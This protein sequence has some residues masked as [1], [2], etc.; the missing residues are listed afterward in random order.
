MVVSRL[1]SSVSMSINQPL[2]LLDRVNV[3]IN[4]AEILRDIT[5]QMK[6]GENWAILGGNGAG[7]STFLRL[8]RGEIWPAPVNGGLRMYGFENTPT[9]SPIGIKKRMRLVSAEQQARYLRQ[10]EWQLTARDIVF[11]GFHDS[12]V[13]WQKPTRAQSKVVDETLDMLGIAS[14]AN[15]HF[16]KMSQG[17]LRRALIGRA[18]VS[19]P[20]VLVLDEVCVG[21]DAASRRHILDIIQQAAERGTQVLMTTHRKDEL[22]PAI[23]HVMELKEGRVERI[24]DRRKTE[25]GRRN[26]L[27]QAV[28]RLPSSVSDARPLIEISNASV[29]LNEGAD[30]VLRGVNWRMNEG[31]HWLITGDNGVGKS[32][33]LKLILGELWPA[34]GGS[35]ARFGERD[36]RNV[37][38]IKKRIGYVS[39]DL[40]ARYFVDVSAEDVIASGFF[41]SVGWLQ[42]TSRKQNARVDELIDLFGLRPLAKRSILEMSY[43][44]ARKVLVA[45]ALA[46][47][48]RILILDEVFDGLDAH[49]RAELVEILERVAAPAALR[50]RP[51]ELD[52]A[53]EALGTSIILVAHHEADILPCIT[54]RMTI[55]DGRVVK[56]EERIVSD[57]IS[58]SPAPHKGRR[59]EPTPNPSRRE[60]SNSAS[61]LPLGGA[62]GGFKRGGD[63]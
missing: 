7:K 55:A 27:S 25:D 62:G 58:P 63:L 37:W 13:V 24:E 28:F 51:N 43:G 52:G 59:D 9:P 4:G 6:R 47:S 53:T 57:A 17:Q 44:Q 23:S 33:L 16:K 18:L 60:G 29:A 19:N 56:L 21:L 45:R 38:E 2:I 1:P 30:V 5:W 48:P 36:F 3:A 61:P 46:N 49:F 26:A 39:A 22:V 42:P 10:H 11:T 31:E 14:L 34:H 32:T 41:A 15:T 20:E 12:E 40:Q 35:I 8:V 50:P 54:H